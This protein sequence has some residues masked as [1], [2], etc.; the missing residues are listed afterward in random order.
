M[1]CYGGEQLTRM[2]AEL[3]SEEIKQI[4]A[5]FGT[6]EQHTAG[7]NKGGGSNSAL[8]PAGPKAEL[9]PISLTILF[10]T[11]LFQLTEVCQEA[12]HLS[13]NHLSQGFTRQCIIIT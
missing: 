4:T 10:P 3:D 6:L 8:E 5:R 7:G 13:S 12:W 11:E 1:S 9:Q 2:Q